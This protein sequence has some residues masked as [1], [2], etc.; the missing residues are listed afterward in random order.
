MPVLYGVLMYMGFSSLRGM[1]FIDRILILF[2]PP[3]YQPD[4]D[5]LRHVQLKRVHLFTFIQVIFVLLANVPGIALV[6]N[7]C[8]NCKIMFC[9]VPLRHT[10]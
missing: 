8:E 5:Y 6:I 4:Q 7:S 2:M 9:K 1:Q 10:I 3:K